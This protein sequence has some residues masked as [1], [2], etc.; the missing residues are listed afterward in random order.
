MASVTKS[1]TLAIFAFSRK[2]L[3]VER[4]IRTLLTNLYS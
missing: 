3:I 1:V 2:C 4:Q